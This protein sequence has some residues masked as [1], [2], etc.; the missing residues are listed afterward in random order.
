MGRTNLYGMYSSELKAFI[1]KN[2]NLFW[3]TPENKKEEISP[4][5][6]VETVLNYGSLDDVKILLKL[7]G[8]SEVAKIFF[9][10]E[11]RKKMNYY[12][13]VYNFFSLFFKRNV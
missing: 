2:S 13:E 1:R 6:L 12:P 7:M 5:F 11:G 3:Y 9:S 4:D 8:T 10:T